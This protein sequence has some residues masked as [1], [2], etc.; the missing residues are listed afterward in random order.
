[1]NRIHLFM[2]FE[3]SSVDKEKRIVWGI[4]TTEKPDLQGDI[5]SYEGSKK[6]FSHWERNCREMHSNKAVGQA[7]RVMFDDK[8]RVVRVGVYV[9]K[10]AEDTWQKVL[11][12]TLRGFSIGGY[13]TSSQPVKK[14]GARR[15]VN[16][17]VLEELSLVDTPANPECEITAI[18]KRGKLL[19][20][21]EVLGLVPTPERAG[22][23][24]TLHYEVKSIM[25]KSKR[26][27][28][29]S[30]VKL[31]K[32]LTT[33]KPEEKLIAVPISAFVKSADGK[34][35]LNPDAACATF[36]KGDL[37]GD[38]YDDEGSGDGSEGEE[39]AD[40]DF[41]G[42]AENL[43]KCHAD[44]VKAAGLGDP[45]EHY[46]NAIDDG[47]EGVEKDDEGDEAAPYEKNRSA[48]RRKDSFSKRD[49]AKAIAEA[50][51]NATADL[52]AA[53]DAKFEAAGKASGAAPRQG[54]GGTLVKRADGEVESS[55]AVAKLQKA[56]AR[57]D[58]ILGGANASA[59]ERT[60]LAHTI[61]ELEVAALEGAKK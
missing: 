59:Q 3:K 18:S 36:T 13:P 16:S 9:S 48:K 7:V 38:G 43:A 8:A 15:R 39:P 30:L 31:S 23:A 45:V 2:P 37:D 4:A 17:Y 61:A 42:H 44:M 28:V 56:Y 5:M 21:T 26:Q 46:T 40:I 32:S 20:A 35:Y 52:T 41:G 11:D 34:M 19:V 49:V 14:N 54:D 22:D 12:G 57:R 60:A 1:M 50:V 33:A 51:K 58:E 25:A 53:F 24:I 47:E 27:K 55:E 10:G 6:A 29:A